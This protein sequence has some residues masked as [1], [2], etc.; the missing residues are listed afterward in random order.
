METALKNK[1]TNAVT[2][3]IRKIPKDVW[4]AVRIQAVKRDMELSEF[5]IDALRKAVSKG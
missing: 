4:D 3:T 1:E 2:T 5:V